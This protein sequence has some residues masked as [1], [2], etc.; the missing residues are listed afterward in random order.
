MGLPMTRRTSD[1]VPG[2][3]SSVLSACAG[4]TRNVRC[5]A[6]PIPCCGIASEFL[7]EFKAERRISINARARI[8]IV[9][10]LSKLLIEGLC[11]SLVWVARQPIFLF[12][13]LREPFWHA[14]VWR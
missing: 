8:N 12:E 5:G 3:P 2:P 6:T 1:N 4:E 13:L 14:L 9:G 7:A 11:T 10:L